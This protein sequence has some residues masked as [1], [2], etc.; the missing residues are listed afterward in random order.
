M[1]TYFHNITSFAELKKQFRILVQTNHP[2]R[3]GNTE[4]MQEIN[5]EFQRLY[6]IW[7]DK[8]PET[9]ATASATGYENEYEGA[10][11]REYAE[12][13]YEEY[14]WKGSRFNSNQT[15]ADIVKIVRKWLKSTYP[16]CKFSV[17][18]NGYNSINIHIMK[19]DFN[20]FVSDMMPLRYSVNV[21][22]IRS[23]K[24]INDRARD[25]LLNTHSFVQS[26][27]YDNTDY[28]S[29]YFDTGFYESIEF[30][31]DNTAFAVETPKERRT[32]G[33]TKPSAPSRMGKAHRAVKKALGRAYFSLYRSKRGDF[34]VL[35]E[36]KIYGETENFYPFTYSGYKTAQKRAEKLHSIG[37]LCEI[38]NRTYSSYMI[39]FIGYTPELEQELA[40]EDLEA[41]EK[42]RTIEEM[43]HTQKAKEQQNPTTQEKN[44]QN[45]P[46]PQHPETVWASDELV[47]VEYSEKAVAVFGDTKAFKEQFKEL[48]GRF[49]PS[50]NYNGERR[51][52]W[53]FSKKQA[54]KVRGLLTP[55][56]SEEEETNIIEW[57]KIPFIGYESIELEYTGEGKE[58]GVIGRMDNGKY[59]GAFGGIKGSTGGL[60]PTRKE[61]DT[62]EDLLDWMKA[63]A[64][65]YKNQPNTGIKEQQDNTPLI[66]ADHAKYCSFDYPTTS[67]ELDGF[68]LGEVAYDQC[69]EIG[70]I[71]AF[72]E[73]NGTARL[74]SN[75]C[76]DVGKLKKCPKEIAEREVKYMDIIRP[77]K[78][79][80]VSAS[81]PYGIS[82]K[83]QL[84]EKEERKPL[85]DTAFA[86]VIRL[87]EKRYIKSGYRKTKSYIKNVLGK[88][89]ANI[90]QVRNMVYLLNE[91]RCRFGEISPAP[92][93][94]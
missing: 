41:A 78:E 53:I 30:G 54:D 22:H 15:N 86:A 48:G 20:P 33:Y 9:T 4:T 93:Y 60:T 49:N 17:N 65:V 5:N 90:S 73:K 38:V 79:N 89:R 16:A 74:N 50:L 8:K 18:Q 81:V 11:A 82:E 87:I 61:F 69:G 88:Y 39:K 59:W 14:G 7:K 67:E 29:D 57:K 71:V 12:H 23:D 52:G 10:T 76:C 44:P 31:N 21:Y 42:T 28:Y 46:A 45:Q 47:F 6:K 1:S 80:P 24:R 43:K 25:I 84:L 34:L 51:A 91:C 63:N 92:P 35:G 64:F 68:K 94:P 62:E 58:F 36:N 3:G 66:I 27:N 40:A 77:Q 19:M 13:V 75:G 32:A 85:N 2:D 83:S 70:I 26:F 55:V 56:K 72:N 37:I